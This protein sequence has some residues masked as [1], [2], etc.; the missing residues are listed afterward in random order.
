MYKGPDIK[1]LA[2]RAYGVCVS[3]S[4]LSL[5]LRNVNRQHKSVAVLILYLCKTKIQNK[6]KNPKTVTTKMSGCVSLTYMLLFGDISNLE[7]KGVSLAHGL[8]VQ[9]FMVKKL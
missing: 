4:V 7:V 9:F 6:T 3:Y 1:F 5:K 2:L 8:R